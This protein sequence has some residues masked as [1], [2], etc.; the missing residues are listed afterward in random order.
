MV[1]TRREHISPEESMN[2]QKFVIVAAL[3]AA[4]I[5]FFG[6]PRLTRAQNKKTPYPSMTPL[7]QYLMPRDAEIALARSAGPAAISRDATVLVLGRKGHET[8]VKGENG[9]VCAV[10]RSRG[11]DF[12]APE[13]WNPKIRAAVCYNPPA[14]RSVFPARAKRQK[15]VLAGLSKTQVFDRIKAAFARKQLPTPEPGSMCYML[16]KEAYLNDRGSHDLAHPDV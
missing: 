4:L 9:F 3:I 8:A 1:N 16:S 2:G 13:F 15:M 7:D 10:E 12:D 11:A 5:F 6:V 14:A